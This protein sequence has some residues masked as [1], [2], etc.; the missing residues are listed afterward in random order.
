[1][2]VCNAASRQYIVQPYSHQSNIVQL[3]ILRNKP[4]LYSYTAQHN[5]HNECTDVCRKQQQ[6]EVRSLLDCESEGVT[7]NG[8][9]QLF[10][11]DKLA[12]Y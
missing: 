9:E 7:Q 12:G 8:I 11:D 1:M 10:I 4:K 5:S 3:P 6:K 2:E